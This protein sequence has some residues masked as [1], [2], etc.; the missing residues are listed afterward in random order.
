MTKIRIGLLL[1][2]ATAFFTQQAQADVVLESNFD[3]NTGA[4]NTFANGPGAAT[5]SG[6]TYTGSA[7]ASASSTLTAIAPG[8]NGFVFSPTFA[9]VNQDVVTISGNL[10]AASLIAEERGFSLTFTPTVATELAQ[11]SV[12]AGHFNGNGGFQGFLS[13]LNVDIS[14]GG[15]SVFSG[16]TILDNGDDP[17]N[18][19]SGTY[20]GFPAGAAIAYDFDASGITLDAGTEYTFSS[21]QN[22][23]QSGGSFAYFNG[24]SIVAVPEPSSLALLAF[25]GTA[26]AARRR[27]K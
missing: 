6:I 11:V 25:V 4:A 14:T 17:V 24:F 15:A 8:T 1:F 27:K 12:I 22:N 21:T 18:P 23:L 2:L 9:N 26:V 3:G 7:A 13:D 16:T 10:N 20:D 19:P 5:V